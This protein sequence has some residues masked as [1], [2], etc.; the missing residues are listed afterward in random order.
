MPLNYPA[1]RGSAAPA[2]VPNQLKTLLLTW[3]LKSLLGGF[4]K[5]PVVFGA[6]PSLHAATAVISAFFVARYSR[7]KGL[8]VMTIYAY[9][10]FWSTM[11]FHHHCTWLV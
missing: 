9:W 11:Y 1:A 10:M 6:F 8:A 4:K 5:S 3:N 2:R 7:R